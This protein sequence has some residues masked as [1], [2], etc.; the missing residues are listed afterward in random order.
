G[1]IARSASYPLAIIGMGAALVGRED[2]AHKVM[3]TLRTFQDPTS[4]GAYSERPEVRTSY[5]QDL[6]PTAQLGMTALTAGRP[7]A[8]EGAFNWIKR[9]YSW[10]PELPHRLFT[11]VTPDGLLLDPSP[12]LE[13][14]AITDFRKPRQAFYNPGIAAAFLAR[15]FMRTGDS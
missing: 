14:M 15:Y 7:D 6:Y 10:Q 1:F 2:L 12:E 9:L 5:L 4:G 13:W 11:T 3:D 8:A